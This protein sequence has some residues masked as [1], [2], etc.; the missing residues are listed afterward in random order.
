MRNLGRLPMSVSL[1]IPSGMEKVLMYSFRDHSKEAQKYRVRQMSANLAISGRN[2]KEKDI[3][4]LETW[5]DEGLSQDEV[6]RRL[7]AEAIAYREESE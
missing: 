1:E 3:Q 5:I 7:T 2:M 4:Q 6:A